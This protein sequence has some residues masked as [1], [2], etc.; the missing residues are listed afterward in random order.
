MTLAV[1]TIGDHL[2]T[3]TTISVDR[4]RSKRH[5]SVIPGFGITLGLT[6]TW[7]AL[8]VLIPLAGL[9]LKTADLSLDQFWSIVSSLTVTASKPLAVLA[10]SLSI[11]SSTVPGVGSWPLAVF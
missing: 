11:A 1:P 2:D 9:F 10:A 5:P 3:R 6:L 4:R 7:L 8:I